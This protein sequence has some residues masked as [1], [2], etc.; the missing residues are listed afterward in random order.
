MLRYFIV[1]LLLIPSTTFGATIYID[2]TLNSDCTSGNYSIANRNCNG[3]DGNAYNDIQTALSASSTNDTINVRYGAVV[4]NASDSNGII[5]KAGQTWQ[6]YPGDMGT[7]RATIQG[8]SGYRAV[9]WIAYKIPNV[10]IK[11]L[12]IV[13]ANEFGI[14]A[15]ICDDLILTNL[16]VSG[17]NI[18][19][20]T[21]K[22]GIG[23]YTLKGPDDAN[24]TVTHCYVHDP[25]NNAK[26]TGGIIIGNAYNTDNI[27]EHN[28]V[29]NVHTGIWLDVNASG[30]VRYNLIR[31]VARRGLRI[32]YLSNWTATHNIIDGSLDAMSIRDMDPAESLNMSHNTIYDYRIGLWIPNIDNYELENSYFNDNIYHAGTKST[33]SHHLQIADDIHQKATNEYRNNIFYNTQT[34]AVAVCWG[35]DAGTTSRACYASAKKYADTAAGIAQFNEDVNKVNGNI[36][37]NPLFKNAANGDFNLTAG[38]P[39]IDAASDGKDIGAFNQPTVSNVEAQGNKITITWDVEFT[40]IQN[41][42]PTKFNVKADNVVIDV[43]SCSDLNG[44]QTEL[45]LDSSIDSNQDVELTGTYGCVEDSEGVGRIGSFGLNGKARTFSFTIPSHSAGGPMPTPKAP[46]NLHVISGN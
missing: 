21:F 2:K 41:C 40:P 13:G 12:M 23:L 24:A 27:V 38:S 9:F 18:V 19:N 22:M 30:V 26:D 7:G 25:A 20:Q 31:N 15:N 33:E 37:G 45:I 28:T 36:T 46:Q 43:N 16:D 39:A 14:Y 35:D 1:L 3:T 32:E 6:T 17:W 44:N 11:D 10:T 42:N 8:G 34:N 5:P 29:E 4:S